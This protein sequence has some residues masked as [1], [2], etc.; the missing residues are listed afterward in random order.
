VADL[1]PAVRTVIDRCLAVRPDENV[2]VVHD[3]YRADIGKA[4]H[5]DALAAGGDSVLVELPPRPERGTEPP[6]PVAGAFAFCDVYLAPCLPSLSHTKARKAAQDRGARGATL[7]GVERDMFA[8]LM[9]AEF[10]LMAQRSARVAG[11]LTEAGEARFTCPKGSEMRFDLSGRTAIA[12]DGDLTEPAAFGNLPCGEGFISPAGGSGVLVATSVG[13]LGI[14][15]ERVELHVE[16]G[17]LTSATGTLGEGLAEHLDA[18]GPDGRHLAELGVGTNDQAQLTGNMLEDEKLLGTVH[19][20]F[21]ASAA[22]GGTVNVPVHE[23]SVVLEPT[24]TIGEETVVEAG[25]FLL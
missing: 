25:R 1:E 3:P 17:R 23:D 22:I 9:S 18:Y 19:V 21:G 12:D 7:P 13:H 10:D 2:L 15:D 16:D 14:T 6:P 11:L 20:A 24:L 8:R 4:L 5:E